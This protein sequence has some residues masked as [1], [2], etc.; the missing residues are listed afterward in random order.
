MGFM[1]KKLFK[2]G[3]V[4]KASRVTVRTLHHY[5]EIGLLVPSRSS[6]GHRFY[7]PDD[8]V[9]LQQILAARALG[10]PLEQIRRTLDDPDLD[11]RALLLEQRNAL[12]ARAAEATRMVTAIDEALAALDKPEGS[13]DPQALFRGFDPRAYEDEARDRWA[14]T[15]TY[16]EAARRTR[17][18][19]ESDWERYEEEQADLMR[20]LVVAME[21]GVDP[22]SPDGRAL[23]EE[24]RLLIDRWFYPCSHDQHATLAAMY[25]LDERFAATF[26]AHAEGLTAFLVCAVRA[27]LNSM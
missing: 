5:D 17:D 14:E 18:Y 16:Q 9:R 12:E 3:D 6:A 27:N 26:E 23:A 13:F 19:T 7:G 10:L 15:G 11:R 8:L 20:R 21:R 24:H 25:E 4:A 1:S 22:A 2:I